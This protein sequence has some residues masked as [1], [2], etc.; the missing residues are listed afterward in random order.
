MS[1]NVIISG[2]GTGGHIFPAIAIA[3]EL[4]KIPNSKVL[5]I[6]AKN[7]M[8]M[9]HVPSA[10]FK[11]K[12]LWISGFN[13]RNYLKNILLPLKIVHSLFKCFLV[14]NKN[15]PNVVV[16]TGGFASGPLVFSAALMGIPSII[17]EQNAF[18]GVT[19]RFLSK[20]VN[21]VCLGNKKAINYFPKKKVIVTG[22]PLRYSS[23]KKS[24][25]DAFK[26]VGLT[27]N[28]LTILV[29]GGSLGSARINQLIKYY[30]NDFM[31][32]NVQLFWQC[33]KI[34]EQEYKTLKN[35]NVHITPFIENMLSA[36]QISDVVISRAGALAISELSFYSK[37]TLFI[38]SPNV[39]ENHQEKNAESLVNKNAALMVREHESEEKFW[40]FIK[41]LIEDD[42]LRKKLSKNISK[43][44]YPKATIEIVNLLKKYSC[45]DQ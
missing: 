15:K 22:N 34:Y 42:F 45:N 3:L 9:S 33:G 29:I 14:I 38:P 25:T 18:P 35:K 21:V 17:Q 11:I 43:N 40:P 4:N 12:G 44:S 26:S 13:R 32:L 31:M 20:F 1:L 8:E 41:K 37:P 16:G 30:L 10:G 23:N 39:S 7:R 28:K 19:N 24:K 36:Y 6:G 5:F 27:P 2:G